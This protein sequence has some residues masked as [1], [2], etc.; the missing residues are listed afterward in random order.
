M[1]TP[2]LVYQ[3]QAVLNASPIMLVVKMYDLA[4]QATY[5]ENA[6]RFRDIMSELIHGLNF[7]YEMSNQLFELYRYCQELSRKSEFENIR[8][9]LEPLRETWEELA[10]IKQNETVEE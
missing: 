10:Q 2:Q 3:Q 1:K 7:D 4:I 5:Q 6:K 9:I 8:E